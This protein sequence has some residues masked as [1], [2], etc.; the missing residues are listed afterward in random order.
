MH[1]LYL[2][3]LKVTPITLYILSTI[4]KYKIITNVYVI[5]SATVLIASINMKGLN[6]IYRK[7][8]NVHAVGNSSN[9]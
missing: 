3:E 4:Y 8:T 9:P 7:A 1:M 6:I 2:S 5:N